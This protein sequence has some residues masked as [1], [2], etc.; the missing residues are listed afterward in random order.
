MPYTKPGNIPRYENIP[1]SINKRLSKD[2]FEDS[3]DETAPLYQKAV[4]DSGYSHR[5]A[6]SPPTAQ[7]PNSAR[8]NHHRDILWYNPSFSKNV[9]TNVGWSFLK[10][11]ANEF[12]NNHELYKI[13]NRNIVKIS[14]SCMTNLKQKNRWT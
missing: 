3:F 4:D 8:R 14:Y 9:A 6:F 5:L 12:L 13:L 7:T 1:N 2:S 10:I 11:L